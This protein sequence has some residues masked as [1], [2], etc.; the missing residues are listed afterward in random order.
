MNETLRTD[1]PNQSSLSQTG[2]LSRIENTDEFLTSSAILQ[3]RLSIK[4]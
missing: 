3:I 1:N 2:N 4:K